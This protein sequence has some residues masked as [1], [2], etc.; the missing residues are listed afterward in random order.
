MNH[1]FTNND[2]LKSEL[3]T[4]KYN[5]E[6]YSFTFYSDNG[7]FSKNKIDFGTKL[8]LETFL[9]NKNDKN[10]KILDVGCG[11]GILGIVISK[12]NDSFSTLIDVNKR[13]LHLSK[14]NV[15][16]NKS[17]C[18]VILS[19]CYENINDNFDVVIT[20]PPIRTGKEN[21]S[22]ILL[23]APINKD[24]ELWTVIRK[25]QGA[26]SFVKIMEKKYDVEIVKKYKGFYIIKAKNN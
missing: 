17:N 13:C 18:E 23:N 9:E 6:D 14:R 25:D 16:L 2:N 3:R 19:D 15:E 24:G 1:Y 8:L 4:L 5:Y 20:N 7:V 11:Y 21:V 10:Q 22:K 26:K 12:V